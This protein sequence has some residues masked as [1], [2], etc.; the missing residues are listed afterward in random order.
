M[1][2]PLSKLMIRGFDI[3]SFQKRIDAR[4]GLNKDGKSII[5]LVYAPTVMNPIDRNIPRYWSRRWMENGIWK[6]EQ[7]DRWVFEKRLEK[8]AYWDACQVARRQYS[9]AL[10][11]WTDLGPP[12]EEYYVF[13]SDLCIHSGFFTESG[14]P[15]C[16]DKA[17]KGDYRYDLNSRYELVKIPVGGR[18]RCWGLPGL[19]GYREPNES[20]M[21]KV[22]KAAQQLK[23]G[24]YYNP[25]APLSSEQLV[26]IEANAN[27][28]AERIAD[29]ANELQE[30]VNRDFNHVH[31][32][33]R[34]ET[35]AKKLY[36]GRYHFMNNRWKAGKHGLTVIDN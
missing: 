29:E 2:P 35:S 28:R 31:G 24:K 36:H 15:E 11:K 3:E 12:P 26:A 4:V 23:H 17:W 7:P 13:D 19:E 21:T 1:Q 6:Y 9:E 22:E 8:E 27:V 16:C 30:E 20:D 32:W 14:E 5:R 34:F 25:Y 10:D 33:R 18:S